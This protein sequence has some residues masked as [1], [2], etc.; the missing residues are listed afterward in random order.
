MALKTKYADVILGKDKTRYKMGDAFVKD[1]KI[2]P[3]TMAL[4]VFMKDGTIN[5]FFGCA[6]A[7]CQ[8][9]DGV[10]IAVV[11]EIPEIVT[12]VS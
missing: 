4:L 8:Y 7:L 11:S 6:Y 5:T 1:I 10:N 2:D 9:D 12:A 3:S